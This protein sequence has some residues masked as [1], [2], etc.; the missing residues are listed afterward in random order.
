M[1]KVWCLILGFFQLVLEILSKFTLDIINKNL[2]VSKVLLKKVFK[3][4][5]YDKSGTF[6]V[7]LILS[8][9]KADV[10]TKVWSSKQD[11]IYFGD[12]KYFEIILILLTKVIW[13][14]VKFL[15]I[16]FLGFSFKWALLRLCLCLSLS[17]S[18]FHKNF[19]RFCKKIFSKKRNQR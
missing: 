15:Q 3:V 19:H 6:I 9:L 16:G 7:A 13:A 11:T 1:L 12:I 10:T 14:H 4:W 8:S 2:E 17:F 5:L 18:Q